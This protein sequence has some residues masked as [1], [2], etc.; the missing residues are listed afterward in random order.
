MTF[1]VA[2]WLRKPPI[3][4]LV[5]SKLSMFLQAEWERMIPMGYI[6][7]KKFGWPEA[8]KH[9]KSSYTMTA[10]HTGWHSRNGHDRC[11]LETI[12]A[13]L[14]M[15]ISCCLWLWKV[16]HPLPKASETGWPLGTASVQRKSRS[17]KHASDQGWSENRVPK[18][19]ILSLIGLVHGN[20][21]NQKPPYI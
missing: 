16:F 11:T 4:D 6:E 2:L 8:T 15:L 9:Q 19:S 17:V 21:C 10:K 7:V 3:D 5:V 18:I 13:V 14:P 1:R 20:I 12:Y